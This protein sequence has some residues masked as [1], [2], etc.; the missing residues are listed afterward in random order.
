VRKSACAMCVHAKQVIGMCVE[1]CDTNH[2]FVRFRLAV[3]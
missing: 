2:C 1:M 3:C